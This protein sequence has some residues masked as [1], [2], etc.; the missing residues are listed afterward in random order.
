[1][2]DAERASASTESDLQAAGTATTDSLRM[3][4]VRLNQFYQG[5]PVFGAQVVVHMNDQG[6]TGVNGDYVPRISV[7]KVPLLTE[8]SALEAALAALQKKHKL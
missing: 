7:E 3:T 5:I 6:I 4:H 8:A 2:S 1:M